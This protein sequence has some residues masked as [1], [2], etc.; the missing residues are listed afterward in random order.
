MFKNRY[1]EIRSGWSVAASLL[2]ILLGQIIGRGLVPEDREDEILI[3]IITTLIYSIIVIGG[4]LLLFRLIYKR[5]FRQMGLVRQGWLSILLHG[6]AMGAISMVLVFTGLLAVGQA[7]VVSVDFAMLFSFGMIVEL[8]S[9]HF[10]MFSEEFITRGF[11]MTA[12][13]TTR[14][15]WIILLVS[16][17]VFSLGHML[18]PGITVLSLFNT[19]LRGLLFAYMFLKSGRLWFSTGFHV[20]WNFI[21]GDVLG[22]MVSG[23]EQAAAFTTVLGTNSLFTGGEHG[24]IASIFATVVLLFAL[25]YTHFMVKPPS[26]PV[27]TIDSDLPLTRGKK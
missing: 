27:W 10:F 2:L 26:F 21:L 15:K 23:N 18:N 14:N 17:L 11:F 13:K 8:I 7:T 9:V 24:P 22:M 3:K 6:Y 5:P 25:I 4:G 16:S 1:G 19:F 20:A 12:L